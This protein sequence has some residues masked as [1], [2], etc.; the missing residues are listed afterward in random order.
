ML[1]IY[2]QW[3]KTTRFCVANEEAVLMIKEVE[4]R[5]D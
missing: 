5:K 4:L 2:S 1:N 3:S